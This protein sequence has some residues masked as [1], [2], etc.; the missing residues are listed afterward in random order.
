MLA[1]IQGVIFH[2]Q[3]KQWAISL[4][5]SCGAENIENKNLICAETERLLELSSDP[6]LKSKI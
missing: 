2:R 1:L 3:N 5:G 6:A 4:F